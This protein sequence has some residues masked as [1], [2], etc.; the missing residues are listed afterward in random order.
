MTAYQIEDRYPRTFTIH[1]MKSMGLVVSL[2]HIIGSNRHVAIT[3]QNGY[4]MNNVNELVVTEN[5]K[6][7]LY[8]QAMDMQIGR[9]PRTTTQSRKVLRLEQISEADDRCYQYKIYR[10]TINRW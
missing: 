5:N 10:A 7:P 4:P 1:Q 6:V 9:K 8:K 2:Y 3:D